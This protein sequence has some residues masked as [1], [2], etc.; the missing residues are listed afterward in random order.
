MLMRKFASSKGGLAFNAH[1]HWSSFCVHFATKSQFVRESGV[2]GSTTSCS[3][4]VCQHTQSVALFSHHS[5][6]PHVVSERCTFSLS[7]THV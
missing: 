4:S 2:H 1:R 7:F 3:L 6:S 5:R